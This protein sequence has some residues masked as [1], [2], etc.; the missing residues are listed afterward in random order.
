MIYKILSLSFCVSFLVLWTYPFTLVLHYDNTD[1]QIA[2]FYTVFFIVW[3]FFAGWTLGQFLLSFRMMRLRSQ[4]AY[5]QKCYQFLEGRMDELKWVLARISDKK[6]L[7]RQNEIIRDYLA[8]TGH[9]FE[10]LEEYQK[11]PLEQKESCPDIHN[12]VLLEGLKELKLVIHASQLYDHPF[13]AIDL[14]SQLPWDF[15]KQIDFIQIVLSYWTQYSKPVQKWLIL[16]IQPA[17]WDLVQTQQLFETITQDDEKASWLETLERAG[18]F[19]SPHLPAAQL[20]RMQNLR[21]LI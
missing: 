14:L 16:K 9:T 20:E 19:E 8:K 15:W 17:F 21:Q 3:L 4:L 1:I 18:W 10:L 13:R 2:A 6:P 7:L 11:A 12:R 5:Y